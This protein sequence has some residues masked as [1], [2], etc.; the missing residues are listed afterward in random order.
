M[1]RLNL[2]NCF[3]VA[4]RGWVG[5]ECSDL[6]LKFPFGPFLLCPDCRRCVTLVRINMNDIRTFEPLK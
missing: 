2:L 5:S 6:V 4:I 1:V 3:E